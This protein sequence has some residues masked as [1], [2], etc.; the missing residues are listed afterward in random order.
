MQW[1][2]RQFLDSAFVSY[3]SILYVKF[4]KF[5]TR[6]F[7]VGGKCPKLMAVPSTGTLS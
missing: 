5:Q 2:C 3:R 6:I 1:E 4:L 7:V